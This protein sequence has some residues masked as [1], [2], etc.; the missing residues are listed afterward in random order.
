MNNK[1]LIIAILAEGNA[2]Q[3]IINVLLEHDALVF[4]KEKLL[5]EEVLRVRNAKTFAK[6]YLNK[7]MDK[8]VKIYRILDS[9]KE[10]FKLPKAY[11]KK[12]DSI[13][14]VHTKPEIEILL[15]LYHD[16]YNKFN[17]SNLKPSSFVKENY[18][19]IANVKSY[20]TVFNFW[21]K[22]FSDL[23]DVLKKYKSMHKDDTT[24]YDLLKDNLK[25][26]CKEIV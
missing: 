11:E 2:E 16:D 17:Q 12:I 18:K 13:V 10:N 5:Q 22:N 20:D 24:I 21:N 4:N 7:G 26:N 1:G 9:P 15:V 6:Q 23:L 8:K 3:A 19:K 14:N 25:Y